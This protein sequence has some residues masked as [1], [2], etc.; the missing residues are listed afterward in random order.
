[1]TT[2]PSRTIFRNSIFSFAAQAIIKIFSFAFSIFVA[3]YLGAESFGQYSTIT[4]FVG[5]F[6]IFSDLG[7]SLYTTRQIARWQD[8]P[9]GKQKASDLYS[10]ILFLRLLLSII[11]VISVTAVAYA[12]H[13]PLPIIVGI[14]VNSLI[15][16][17]YAVQGSSEAVLGGFERLDITSSTKIINQTIFV[18]VGGVLLWAGLGYFG[19]I[20]ANLIGVFVMMIICWFAVKKL[21]LRIWRPNPETWIRLLTLSIP[22]G[23]IGFTLGLSYKFDTVLL[24]IFRSDQETGYYNAAY[25]LI[26]SLVVFSNA[27]NTAL[28]PSLSRISVTAPEKLATFYNRVLRYLMIISLPIAVGGTILADQIISLLYGNE[29][30]PSV[31]ALRILIWVLPFMYAS[32][33]LGYVIVIGNKEARVARAVIIS[34]SF[35]ILL[36]LFLV[37]KYG[38][39]AASIM[40]VLTEMILVGQYIFYLRN[41]VKG[42]NYIKNVGL[43][44]LSA[45]LMGIAVFYLQTRIN[46]IPNILIGVVVYILV[47]FAIGL[48][49]RE[50]ISFVKQFFLP[51]TKEL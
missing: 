13:R 28:Y 37:P 44:F 3:R 24:N 48:I 31:I 23:I 10:N 19:L 2:K 5:T 8:V 7:L 12:T 4:A 21:G 6:A 33:F 51:S 30:A 40:T 16:V 25:N 29:Y 22:F 49:G 43:P 45:L 46:L 35:N 17:L 41:Q 11:T 32:E 36:N 39:V 47:S 38:Y 1:M 15:L 27:I 14:A 9:E 20:F 42:M 50:E 18:L 26:F 34:T